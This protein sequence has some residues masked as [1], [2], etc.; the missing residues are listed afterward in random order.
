MAKIL[1]DKD[2]ESV[3]GGISLD[4]FGAFLENDYDIVYKKDGSSEPDK[5][6]DA[7]GYKIEIA[8]DKTGN[9]QEQFNE[10]NNG[11]FSFNIAQPDIR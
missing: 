9:Y 2:L 10:E 3:N 8:I 1:N 6:I 5:P 11:S 7:G 4:G